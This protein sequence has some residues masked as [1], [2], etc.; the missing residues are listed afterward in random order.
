MKTLKKIAA[1]LLILVLVGAFFGWRG[2]QR[3]FSARETPTRV[4]VFIATK[5][6]AL[7]VP[8]SYR[9]LKN[10]LPNSPQNIRAGMEHF[11]DHCFLC[12]ANNGSG[13]TSFGKNLYPKPPDMRI[14]ET[15]NKSDGELFYTIYN[16][17]RLSGMPAFGEKDQ[18]DA[19]ATWQLVRFLRHLPSLT[20]EEEMQMEKLNPRS[21]REQGEENEEERFLKGGK[22]PQP[23]EKMKHH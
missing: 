4:E 14:A 1:P 22:P 13:D 18:S 6:R 20:E 23:M 10:P 16:G 12:H 3:G 11:A 15:Q 5:A 8:A 19:E 9:S 2:I 21:P 7:A 17:V